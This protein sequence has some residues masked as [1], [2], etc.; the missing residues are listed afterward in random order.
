M[1]HIIS[2]LQNESGA[3]ARVAAMF[4]NHGFNIESLS[5]A[6]L[7]AGPR[8][9][10]LSTSVPSRSKADDVEGE[11]VHDQCVMPDGTMGG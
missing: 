4:A 6:W 2:I 1:R 7:R 8:S 9:S 10:A 5:R 11:A 3:L